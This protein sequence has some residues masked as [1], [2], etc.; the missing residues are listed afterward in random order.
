MVDADEK[1]VLMVTGIGPLNATAIGPAGE[2][3]TP[4]WLRFHEGNEWGTGWTFD[5]PGCWDMHV[6]R[7]DVTGD[8]WF[9]VAAPQLSL[10]SFSA[11]Q[12]GRTVASVRPGIRTVFVVRGSVQ[13]YNAT[14]RGKLIIRQGNRLFGTFT[15]KTPDAR[16][17]VLCRAITLPSTGPPSFT[18][19]AQVREWHITATKVL[20]LH[21]RP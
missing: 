21:R 2:V 7:G 13:N 17:V 5:A 18:V 6:A 8:L 14:P 11:S 19:T 3:I 16:Y 1:F 9:N 12:N 15:L 20:H 10:T 4:D